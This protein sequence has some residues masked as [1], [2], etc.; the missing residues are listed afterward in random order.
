MPA[1]RYGRTITQSPVA[2]A[3]FSRVTSTHR[4]SRQQSC[5]PQPAMAR[6]TG[7]AFALAPASCARTARTQWLT[8]GRMPLC[9]TRAPYRARRLRITAPARRTRRPARMLLDALSDSMSGAVRRLR[10]VDRIS[11]ANVRAPLK[12]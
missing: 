3:T 9:V 12:D 4:P 6:S 10:G 11:E 5:V 7:S 2:K 1:F 8:G